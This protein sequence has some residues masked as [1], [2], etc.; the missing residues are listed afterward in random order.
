VRRLEYSNWQNQFQFQIVCLK[1]FLCLSFFNY[2]NI[3]SFEKDSLV[4]LNEDIKA[5]M[6]QVQKENYKLRSENKQLYG[7]KSLI[8]QEIE[9]DT[10][11]PQ[12]PEV[13][14]SLFS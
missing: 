7:K 1:P 9:K 14:F 2:Y 5:D 10:S 13:F 4:K 11:V 12:N 3:N 8:L 6:Q